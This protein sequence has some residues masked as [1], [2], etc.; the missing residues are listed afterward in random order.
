[1]S[2]TPSEHILLESDER[3]IPE[4]QAAGKVHAHLLL[5]S[6]LRR[7][8]FEL[9][10]IDYYFLSVRVWRG[11]S[12]QAQYT[13]DLRFVDPAMFQ[14]RHVAWRWIAATVTWTALLAWC[15]WRVSVASDPWWQH[16]WWGVWSA[17]FGAVALGT[18]VSAYRTTE[19]FVLRSLHGKAKLL[20][21]TAGL[22]MLRAMRSF[23]AKL[24]AHI[25]LAIS[26]RRPTRAAHL[27]DEMREH[28]RLKE[29][30]VIPTDE[31][32][33][34]KTRILG[35]HSSPPSGRTP[36]AVTM[37]SMRGQPPPAG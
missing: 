37:P 21:C 33:A 23:K 8:R 7:R 35:S 32:E 2:T 19:H 9:D 3:A 6:R 20:E 12:P 13:L 16:G 25:Q 17:L 30:G 11:K 4:R 14:S 31:Y 10:V 18:V 34:S 15:V 26:A 5:R 29:A 28:F 22:G 27:R 1:M 24:S 36:S